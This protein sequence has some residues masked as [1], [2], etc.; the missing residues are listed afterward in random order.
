MLLRLF[1]DL[2]MELEEK[3][4]FQE[5][6]GYY[7]VDWGE[8]SGTLGRDIEAQMFRRLRKSNLWPIKEKCTDYSEE[9]VFDV[10]EFLYDH[11]S[12][13]LEGSY[14]SYD[15]CGW[16][17]NTFDRDAGRREYLSDINELLQ[18]YQDGY[19]LSADGEILARV[20]TGMERLLVA[21]LPDRDSN[22]IEAR[23]NAAVL[24]FRRYRSSVEDR[25]DAIRN[26]ADVLEFLR[27]QLKSVL[28]RGDESDLFNIANNF[29]IRHHNTDQKTDYD[30]A[31]WYSWMFYYYLATI[32]AAVRLIEK[33]E[34]NKG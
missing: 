4:Y 13:P 28:T 6:C 29:S 3:Y 31:I 30:K 15:N 16:H 2:Y 25:R 24:K 27:P 33:A 17:Y 21:S 32:H 18:D 12:K 34:Q 5:A 10:I 22:N 11:T 1:K 8:V 23:V 14:H 26:L 7:C 20:E 9:D 19:E